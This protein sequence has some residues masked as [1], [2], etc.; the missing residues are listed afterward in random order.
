MLLPA[1]SI[2]SLLFLPPSASDERE[3]TESCCCA[4]AC[5]LRAKGSPFPTL[6]LLLLVVL[7]G[8]LSLFSYC[9]LP[10]ICTDCLFFGD[11]SQRLVSL[12][13]PPFFVQPLYLDPHAFVSCSSAAPVFFS[14]RWGQSVLRMRSS[15]LCM[16]TPVCWQTEAADERFRR[17]IDFL[18]AEDRRFLDVPCF[19][20]FPFARRL[21]ARS[22]QRD[23]GRK[24]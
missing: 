15:F 6:S 16:T 23:G 10:V 2:V 11:R 7:L 18:L 8:S 12:A 13:P 21:V 3:E 5:F 14:W 4:G 17:S 22:I 19:R 1:A 9:D 20:R 24:C